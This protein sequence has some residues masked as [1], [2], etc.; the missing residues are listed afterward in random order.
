MNP[1]DLRRA[2]AVL[3]SFPI[4][5]DFDKQTAGIQ[6]DWLQVARA[7]RQSDDAAGFVLVPK[8]PTDA[9]LNAAQEWLCEN[10][11]RTYFN[12]ADEAGKFKAMIAAWTRRAGM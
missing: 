4:P 9:M 11:A 7:I 8:E 2:K 3:A 1:H 12:D 6:A 10:H 5:A